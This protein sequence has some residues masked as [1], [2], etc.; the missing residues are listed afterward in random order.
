[1]RD[2][3]PLKLLKD[4]FEDE[5]IAMSIYKFLKRKSRTKGEIFDKLAEMERGHADFW[6]DLT[7]KTYGIKLKVG[8]KLKLKILWNKFIALITPLTFMINYL[9]LGERG[10]YLEYS[11]ILEIVK[12]D[13]ELYDK[14]KQIIYDEIEHEVVFMDMILGEKSKLAK[15]KDAIYGMTDSLVEI[16]AL[17]IGLASVI[18]SPLTVGL[19][20]LISAVG[21]TFSMTSGAYL[22]SKSQ[23]DLYEGAVEEIKIK[24]I[25]AENLLT[26]DLEKA[27]IERGLN[28]ESARLLIDAVKDDA[29]ILSNLLKSIAIE[30]TPVN[31]KEVATTTGIYYVL[32]A[33]PAVVPFFLAAPL[34]VTSVTVAII[35]VVL[36]SIVAFLTG[37]FTG[38]LSGID[39]KR[40]AL[41]NVLIIIGATAATY[42]I[43]TLAKIFLGIEI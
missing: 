20:G 1:L 15:I 40:K 25:L 26:R 8:L 29:E 10:A 34:G 30:E 36:S 33:L 22:S 27:L 31:P 3:I 9:E 17:V 37:I 6:K 42:L 2:Q 43:G 16:L 19:A 32:G 12:S 41:E 4:F 23:N 39:V 7:E 13:A 14:V 35:A 11:K 38:V 24:R 18:T 21:G 5:I 28:K